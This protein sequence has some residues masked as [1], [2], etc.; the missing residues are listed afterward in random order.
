[1]ITIIDGVQLVGKST[2]IK[3]LE[4]YN[5][6][7]YKFEFGKYTKLFNIDNKKIGPFQLGKDLSMLY[8]L[9]LSNP[10]SQIIVDRGVFSTIYYSLL[11][12]RLPKEDIINLLN[13]ISEDYKD[14]KFI[15]IIPINKQVELI[16]NKDD[17]FNNLSKEIDFD[18]LSFIEKECY[19]RGI[20]FTVF[21]NDFTTP[22]KDNGVKLLETIEAL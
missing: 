21:A 8:W 20:K 12:N 2:L 14:Y 4:K 17:N 13:I 3:E 16:R 6:Y 1:M 9:R 7:S 15:F 11:F 18:I 10:L 22:I 5:Y 19:N